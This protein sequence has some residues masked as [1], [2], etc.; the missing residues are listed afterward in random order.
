MKEEEGW[1]EGK[2]DRREKGN[3]KETQAGKMNRK[4][5]DEKNEVKEETWIKKEE[6]GINGMKKKEGQKE[7]VNQTKELNGA[8]VPDS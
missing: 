8:K 2:M 7:R 5:K 6:K 4:K 1:N 3:T